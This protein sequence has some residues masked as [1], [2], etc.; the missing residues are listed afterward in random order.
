MIIWKVSLREPNNKYTIWADVHVK[1]RN[2][3]D[4]ASKGEKA[5]FKKFG[6]KLIACAVKETDLEIL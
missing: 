5:G 3:T 6:I 4:A 1:A 2:I